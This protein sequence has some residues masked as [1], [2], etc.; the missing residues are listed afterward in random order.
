MNDFNRAST[1]S[2]ATDQAY[3]DEGL[4]AH[5][6]RIYNYMAAALSLTGIVLGLEHPPGFTN[7]LLLHL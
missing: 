1:A 3:I 5:M 7:L 2:R 4:R 6:L